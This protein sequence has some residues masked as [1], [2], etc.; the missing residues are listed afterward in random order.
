MKLA[1][2]KSDSSGNLQNE[3]RYEMMG[4]HYINQIESYPEEE[5]EIGFAE[6]SNTR[7]VNVVPTN[8]GNYGENKGNKF[9]MSKLPPVLGMTQLL[10]DNMSNNLQI[11]PELDE[12]ITK[13]KFRYARKKL[14]VAFVEYYRALGLLK[15]FRYVNHIYNY[16]SMRK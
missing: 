13:K 6:S 12:T 4:N 15:T 9:K 11:K 5:N 3:T 1:L 8:T 2:L 7:Q 10:W 14:R 16:F